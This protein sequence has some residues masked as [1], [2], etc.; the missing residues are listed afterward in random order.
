MV[1]RRRISL[2]IGAC[3]LESLHDGM[4]LH[5]VDLV[6]VPGAWHSCLRAIT[7]HATDRTRATALSIKLLA[8]DARRRMMWRSGFIERD[9]K[10][11]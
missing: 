5:I 6:T 3:A 8:R 7:R 2:A 4:E 1:T 11:F 10:P 9:G